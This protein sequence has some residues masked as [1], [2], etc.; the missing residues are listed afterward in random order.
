[1]SEVAKGLT[2]TAVVPKQTFSFKGKR[3]VFYEP[4]FGDTIE[5]VARVTGVTST[6]I[7]RWNHL[8]PRAR[9]QE[10]MRLQLFIDKTKTPGNVFLFEESDVRLMKVNSQPFFNHY[11]GRRGKKR[12]VVTA[13]A[14][15]TYKSLAKHHGVRQS[16][17][18]RINR[19]S[20]RTKLKPGDKVV[21]YVKR[22]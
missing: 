10:G 8:G 11:L 2:P 17:L 13:K 4:V 16:S 3:R 7:R 15:D 18:E 9:L 21:I 20:R 19:R 12:V 5:D 1:M 14:G 6:E 22:P